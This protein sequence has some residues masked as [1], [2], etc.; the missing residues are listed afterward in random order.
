MNNDDIH[1]PE[2]VLSACL[3]SLLSLTKRIL[4]YLSMGGISDPPS[5][6][7]VILSLFDFSLQS[8]ITFYNFEN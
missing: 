4:L 6:D 8:E 1:Q 5:L 7:F 3:M 2:L